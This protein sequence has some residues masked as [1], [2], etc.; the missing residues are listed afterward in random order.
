M[1]KFLTIFTLLVS[2]TGC[3]GGETGAANGDANMESY[4]KVYKYDGSVK[5]EQGSGVA[6]DKMAQELINAGVDVTCSQKGHD[7][8]ARIAMCG[9]E[10]GVMNI[11][12][13]KSSSL[14]DALRIGFKPVGG[15]TEY[16]DEACK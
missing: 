15:L 7:G 4:E 8:K 6:L 11:Y 9:A 3:S 1:K 10:T 16:R 13:I 14:A 5:C 2:L 12:T